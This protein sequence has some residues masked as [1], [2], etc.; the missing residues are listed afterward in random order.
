[1]S[2]KLL[3][4]QDDDSLFFRLDGESTVKCGAIGYMRA[5]FGRSGHEF[6]STWFDE[7]PQLNT[8]TFKQEFD[9]IINTLRD[10]GEAPPFAGRRKL[11]AFCSATPSKDLEPI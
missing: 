7:Q 5:D 3:P 9:E 2:Y 11:E 10:D 1:M 6:W 4:A 8:Y